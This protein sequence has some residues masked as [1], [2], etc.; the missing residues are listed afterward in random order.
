MTQSAT[1]LPSYDPCLNYNAQ[2]MRQSVPLMMKHRVSA[3]PINYA[4]WYEYVAGH[5]ARLKEAVD[6]LINENCE[7]DD[8]TSLELYKNYICHAS[9]DSFEKINVDL[10]ALIEKTASTVLDSSHQ[11]VNVGE[12]VQADSLKLETLDDLVDVKQVL[13]GIMAETRQLLDISNSLKTRLYEANQELASLR[14][15]L[16]KV[17]EMA[18]T[19][20]LTSLLNRR[21]FDELLNE[22]VNN[23]I[24]P[25]HCL[26]I[27]DLDHFKR[28]NDSF[29][30]LVGDKV[31]RF[32]A[33]LIKKYVAEHHYAARYGGEEM[34]VVMPNT[35]VEEALEIAEKIRSALAD[36]HLK[37]KDNGV[38]IGKV[39]ISVGATSLKIDDSPETFISRADKALYNAKKTGRN[40]VVYKDN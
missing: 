22:L 35:T 39:T 34:A 21:A 25:H 14:D 16:T 29:G 6:E 40:K 3:H 36:N 7:F 2:L 30:H 33:G 5:N 24:D 19:D 9:V 10:Q 11:V 26:L 27:L 23:S 31:L 37:Q 12:N 1:F 4:I 18:T 38:L 15:E 13:S 32:T 28:I 17:R 8:K 20:A